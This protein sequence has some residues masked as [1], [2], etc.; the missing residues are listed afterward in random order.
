MADEHGPTPSQSGTF[1]YSEA[2]R[3]RIMLK[4]SLFDEVE[5]PDFRDI[6]GITDQLYKLHERE[7]KQYFHAVTLSDYLRKKI[8]PR[9]LRLQKAPAIGLKNS[10]FCQR[11]TE[12]LNKCSFDLM[13]L[14]INELNEQLEKTRAEV[15]QLDAQLIKELSDKKKLTELKKNIEH[16][17]AKCS[18]EIRIRKKA[19]FARDINDYKQNKV[20]FWKD[21]K[22]ER[23]K[24]HQDNARHGSRGRR[25]P[26]RHY[27][28]WPSS[29]SLESGSDTSSQ[30]GRAPFLGRAH[31]TRLPQW[32]RALPDISHAGEGSG[33][34]RRSPRFAENNKAR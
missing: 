34:R 21:G 1:E 9:G 19:K 14:T 27:R 23:E 30:P 33:R 28:G 3:A 31:N 2:E 7:T 16:Y 4:D 32:R 11:W 18:N 5:T 24:Q 8:I 15:K 20:Y 17:V 10:D 29:S 25:Q 13:A 12:I 6:D 22:P 26:N